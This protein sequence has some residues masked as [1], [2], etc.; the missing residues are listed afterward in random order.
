MLVIEQDMPTYLTKP[1]KNSEIWARFIHKII[2]LQ[3]F[4]PENDQIYDPT[5]V[6]GTSRQS[7]EPIGKPL[8]GE[9]VP[10]F[11][12][13]CLMCIPSNESVGNSHF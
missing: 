4:N 2:V 7:K 8:I 1:Y 10:L 13:Q 12:G 5:I 3:E 9:V 11:S 6:Q